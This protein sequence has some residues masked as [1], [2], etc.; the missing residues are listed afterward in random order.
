MES[1]EDD[2]T[3]AENIYFDLVFDLEEARLK[4]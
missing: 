3:R 4:M 2:E 1:W